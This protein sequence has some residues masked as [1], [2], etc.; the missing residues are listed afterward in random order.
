[1]FKVLRVTDEGLIAH[2]D[3]SQNEL[4]IM[5]CCWEPRGNDR[6]EASEAA[7]PRVHRRLTMYIPSGCRRSLVLLFGGKWV[8]SCDSPN[9]TR[10][11]GV[12]TNTVTFPWWGQCRNSPTWP[13][14]SGLFTSTRIR[15]GTFRGD[16]TK[17]IWAGSLKYKAPPF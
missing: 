14:C 6:D 9:S 10:L 12:A 11:G 7:N 1:M 15:T 2:S 17:A 8:R 3:G 16:E 13:A 4:H 5:S